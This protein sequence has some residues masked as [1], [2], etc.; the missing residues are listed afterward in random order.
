MA[1]QQAAYDPSVFD[2]EDLD[3]AKAIILTPEGVSSEERWERETPYLVS[4]IREHLQLTENSVVVDY[5]CGIGRI[6]RPLIEQVGCRVIGVD[7][8]ASMRA[9][10]AS[11]VDSP[12]FMAC[13]PEM[14]ELLGGRYADA[15]LA[16]WVLQHV[17]TPA[18]ELKL[19]RR[20]LKGKGK[21]KLFLVN[22]QPHLRAVPAKI[23]KLPGW[24]NDKVDVLFAVGTAGLAEVRVGSLDV[25]HVGKDVA[26][27]GFWGVY[28]RP[29]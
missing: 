8:S 12:K 5:G 11:Y 16:V 3:Q 29:V 2:V 17:L 26:E 25:N 22:N 20:A 10:A 24:V 4:L 21:G 14:L 28:E 18:D 23:E 6:T 7:I 13:A 27:F 15:V 19:I 1:A 9:L